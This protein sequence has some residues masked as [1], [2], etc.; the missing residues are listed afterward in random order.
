MEQVFPTSEWRCNPLTKK[1]DFNSEE[2]YLS[3]R[4]VRVFKQLKNSALS[5]GEETEDIS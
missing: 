2:A 1:H 4:K 3:P 5:R